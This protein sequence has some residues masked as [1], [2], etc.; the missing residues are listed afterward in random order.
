MNFISEEVI[1]QVLDELSE[2]DTTIEHLTK[3]FAEAQPFL[4][5]FLL[6]EGFEVLDGQEKSLLFYLQWSCISLS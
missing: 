5:S 6:S 2:D 4:L 1:N 3:E